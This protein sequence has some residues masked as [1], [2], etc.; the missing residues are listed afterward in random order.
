[1]GVQVPPLLHSQE[2]SATLVDKEQLRRKLHVALPP[3]PLLLTKGGQVNPGKA[4]S[5]PAYQRLRQ[6]LLGFFSCKNTGMRLF[7]LL[8]N[9][10]FPFPTFLFPLVEQKY[11]GTDVSIFSCQQTNQGR[12]C[13]FPQ[14]IGFFLTFFFKGHAYIF[15]HYFF[16]CN[17]NICESFYSRARSSSPPRGEEEAGGSSLLA[18]RPLWMLLT[19]T[20]SVQHISFLCQRIKSAVGRTMLTRMTWGK[21]KKRPPKP[22][23]W[24]T[25][26]RGAW[27]PAGLC[28]HEQTLGWQAPSEGNRSQAIRKALAF[29]TL[30]ASVRRQNTFEAS[31]L[32]SFFL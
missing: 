3:S 30:S 15:C 19:F 27:P 28:T 14:I 2:E 12:I 11:L 9:V 13:N 18:E 23:G 24:G 4:R 26:T 7:R 10:L 8:G 20:S 21:K 22:R 17:L 1:M 32:G 31:C 29:A 6:C 25:I 5:Y 16:I